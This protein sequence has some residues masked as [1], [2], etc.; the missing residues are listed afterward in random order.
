MFKK[1]YIYLSTLL[2][3]AMLL[4]ACD[5][6]EKGHAGPLP[7]AAFSASSQ[8]IWA[9]DT[10]WFFDQSTN[11]PTLWTWLFQGG[12]PNY[13]NQQNPYVVYPGS[14]TYTVN[15]MAR[16]TYGADNLIKEGYIVVSAPPV[17]DIE[18]PAQIRLEFE[19][20][21]QST[22]LIDLIAE[23]GGAA[24]YT[25]RPGGGGAYSFNGSNALTLSGYNGINGAGHRSVAMWVKTTT[26]SRGVMANWGAN[27]TFSRATFAI[28]P[29]GILR[30][31]YFGGGF[32]AV[33]VI[34]DNQWHH[35]AYTYDGS[36]IIIYVNGV[37]ESRQTGVTLRTAEVGE[38]EVT[39]GS[40]YG[41]A[42]W[43]GAIDDARIFDVALTPDEVR[44][45]SEIR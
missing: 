4:S 11:N 6:D 25:I 1:T 34:T 9:G 26:T 44:I 38:T 13:S 22:G 3:A 15:M 42:Q 21:L 36:N 40:Q 29:A 45:L 33:T 10:V 41:T 17:I 12:E 31:E 35:V 24:D 27:G 28:Q 16:N 37:E 18:T 43:V 19:N 5:E 30:F 2:M 20:N 14:G 7:E 39:I 32:N 23:T 8:E